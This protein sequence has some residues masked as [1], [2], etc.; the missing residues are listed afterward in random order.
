[1][2]KVDQRDPK[3]G[4]FDEIEPDSADED[5]QHEYDELCGDRVINRQ[6][7]DDSS[8]RTDDQ[9][10]HLKDDIGQAAASAGLKIN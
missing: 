10:A 7:V 2:P 1:M 4:M 9:F 5:F 8:E 6:D 3:S